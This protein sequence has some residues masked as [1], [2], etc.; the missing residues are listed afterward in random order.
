MTTLTYLHVESST[1]NAGIPGANVSDQFG[2]VF[3]CDGTG[4]V[5][6][7]WDNVDYPQFQVAVTA[8][9]YDPAP[10]VFLN[11]LEYGITQTVELQPVGTGTGTGTGTG[12]SCF[13]VTAATGSANSDEVV[14]LREL[15]STVAG[16]SVLAARLIDGVYDEYRRFS[17]AVASWM[18][19]DAHARQ[20]ARE[21][22]V[23][24]VVAWYK[25][26]GALAL[27]GADRSIVEAAKGAAVDACPPELSPWHAAAM[28]DALRRGEPL[29]DNL[30]SALANLG[31]RL[32]SAS[33]MPLVAWAIFEPLSRIWSAAIRP[34]DLV[35]D[36][37]AW[38]ATAPLDR[39]AAPPDHELE[40]QIREVVSLLGFDPAAREQLVARLNGA[41]PSA[42]PAL[43]R[44]G[45]GGDA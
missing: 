42:G 21:T 13:I 1:T 5:G 23:T 34:R 14:L 7:Y 40:A 3:T 30:P 36:V 25:L 26:A 9:G 44:A 16:S 24:P 32:T 37:A 12:I 15:R 11:G 22:V 33:R 19:D 41:W 4:T 43:S 39:L 27:N 17:P 38:L 10:N 2:D 18:D 6:I 31:A 8:A 29:P 35:G 28:F 20:H 45:F